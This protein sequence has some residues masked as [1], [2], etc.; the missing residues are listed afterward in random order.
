MPVTVRGTDIL[1]N[2]SST[3]SRSA[4]PTPAVG[5]VVPYSAIRSSNNDNSFSLGNVAEAVVAGVITIRIRAKGG[6]TQIS[7]GYSSF[8]ISCAC[9]ARVFIN[10]V[11]VGSSAV[12][13]SATF[14]GVVQANYS[15]NPGDVIA[16]GSRVSSGDTRAGT[17]SYSQLEIGLSANNQRLSLI[18]AGNSFSF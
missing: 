4:F 2:D 16:I 15:V 10:G 13:G 9:E 5:S 11:A 3:Q 8:S 7:D 1:F 17:S 6:Q 12:S 18:P 14:S